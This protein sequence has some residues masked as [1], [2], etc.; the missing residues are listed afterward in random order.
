MR[1]GQAA[2]ATGLEASAI[3]FY[4]SSNVVP[5]PQRTASGYRDYQPTDIERLGF[6]RTLRSL[7]L[8]LDDIREIISLR[9]HGE[10]PCAK[11]RASLSREKAVI[12]NRIAQLQRL[13]AEIAE[14]QEKADAIDDDWPES[15]VCQIL[16]PSSFQRNT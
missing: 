6:V 1:I 9:S 7:D 12:E 14:L 5:L 15:C 16:V 8:P 3:R 2:K 10:A 4:E 11:V 13:K